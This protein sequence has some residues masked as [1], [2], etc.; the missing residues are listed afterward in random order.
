MEDSMK[1]TIMLSIIVVCL[2]VAGAITLKSRRRSGSDLSEFKDKTTWVKC[3]NPQCGAEYEVNLKEYFE[4]VEEN[5][6]RR[7]LMA[8]AMTCKECG[9][10]SVYR[11]I[12]CNG[13]GLVF[14]AGSVP[15][16]FPDRCP[17][18]AFSQMEK[19]RQEKRAKRLSG[20]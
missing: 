14:E 2:V 9:E 5:M 15:R 10:P 13:C 8:P 3:R 7:T 6:D 18:C 19:N 12:K 11:A 17:K 16:D 4:Y 1:K 20:E